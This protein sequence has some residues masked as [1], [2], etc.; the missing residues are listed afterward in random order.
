MS[1]NFPVK[2][3]SEAMPPGVTLRFHLA[4]RSHGNSCSTSR[5]S[6]CCHVS[7]P[8]TEDPCLEVL[9]PRLNVLL[10]PDTVESWCYKSC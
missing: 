7:M 2:L 3:V 6:I 5:W 8:P 10:S 4:C 9:W 1:Q